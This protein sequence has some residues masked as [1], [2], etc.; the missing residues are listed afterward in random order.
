MDAA[1]S[2]EIPRNLFGVR[3][4]QMKS[5]ITGGALSGAPTVVD[6]FARVA[7]VIITIAVCLAL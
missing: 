3:V 5:M 1:R 2:V 7:L 6:S 4:V